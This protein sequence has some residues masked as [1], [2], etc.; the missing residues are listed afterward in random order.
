VGIT[1]RVEG[2]HA[3]T[4][5]TTG[6]ILSLITT[7]FSLRYTMGTRSH[8]YA[9]FGK[10]LAGSCAGVCLWR[11]LDGH[12]SNRYAATFLT[13]WLVVCVFDVQRGIRAGYAA[14]TEAL[15]HVILFMVPAVIAVLLTRSL[16]Q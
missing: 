4:N 9:I 6:E 8:R 12:W 3:G 11:P 1:A 16:R 5:S 15:I 7:V 13:F 2:L 10:W 14:F